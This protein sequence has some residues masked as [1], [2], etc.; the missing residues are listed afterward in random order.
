MTSARAILG[1]SLPDGRYRLEAWLRPDSGPV[2]VEAG[3]VDL[4]VP[5]S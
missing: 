4:S 3:T 2:F 1:D 5:R